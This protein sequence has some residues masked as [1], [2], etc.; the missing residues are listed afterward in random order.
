M[1]LAVADVERGDR[2]WVIPLIVITSVLV[3]TAGWAW[4][5]RRRA[6]PS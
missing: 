3:L 4:E 6:H 2:I 5:S 1:F